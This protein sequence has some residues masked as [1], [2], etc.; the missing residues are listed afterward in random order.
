VPFPQHD[1]PVHKRLLFGHVGEYFNV[2]CT[3]AP[4]PFAPMSFDTT[5]VLTALHLE[6]N[7]YLSLF[8]KENKPN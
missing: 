7:G 4:F 8:L 1:L 2:T 6:S 3:L 5:L